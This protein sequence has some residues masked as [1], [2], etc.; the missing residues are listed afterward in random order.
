[1]AADEQQPREKYEKRQ[2]DKP[3]CDGARRISSSFAALSLH[4]SHS[5][6]VVTTP[7]SVPV[8]A[9]SHEL[10]RVHTNDEFK[11]SEEDLSRRLL[12]GE[13][14]EAGVGIPEDDEG[15]GVGVGKGR[16]S[17][18]HGRK[19]SISFA[20]EALTSDG[21]RW[22]LEDPVIPRSE[23]LEIRPPSTS[24]NE[25]DDWQREDQQGSHMH[26]HASG[27][28][29]E[30]GLHIDSI[31]GSPLRKDSG[32]EEEQNPSDGEASLTSSAMTAS[33]PV[34]EPLT[35]MN[36]VLSPTSA[37]S[38]TSTDGKKPSPF[39][40]TRRTDSQRSRSYQRLEKAANGTTSRRRSTRS[41]N[42]SA[43]P[44]SAFLAQWSRSH[45]S[46]PSAEEPDDEGMEIADSGWIIG[47]TI[48]YGG[49]STVKEVSTLNSSSGKRIVRA[50]K[51]MRKRPRNVHDSGQNE[52][53]QA[54]FEHE[55]ALWRFL[56]HRY[57][58]PLIAV[59]DTPFATFCVTKLNV[60]GTLHDL[61]RSRRQ[62]Y[63]VADRGLS[64][65]L[66][67]RYAYQLA[68]AIRY[69]H[70]DARIVHRD[71]KLENC[72]L[73]MTAPDSASHG[74]NI[75]LCDF[76]MADY[77]QT[78]SRDQGDADGEAHNIGP[79]ASSSNLHA[80]SANGNASS[81]ATTPQ[82]LTDLSNRDTS[83]TIMGSLEYAAPEVVTATTTLFSPKADV[84][85]FGVC[86]YA[87]LTAS[88]P[89]S[90]GMREALALMIEKS[91]WDIAPLYSAPAV[92]GGGLAGMAAVELVKGCLTYEAEE[93][94]SVGEVLREKWFINCVELYGDG[95]LR[96]EEVEEWGR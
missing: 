96:E 29:K 4:P 43:S 59:Y 88:L 77:I 68:A 60:G 58:V 93:R 13:D 39:W 71:I 41:A 87:L 25:D 91:Q 17:P 32:I 3:A 63:S 74:G 65:P 62:Q 67:K 9:H 83:L 21:E 61:I 55:V 18:Q 57:I 10:L 6:D 7:V 2:I 86:V 8:H 34:A 14:I 23:P 49:F 51:I 15:V 64:A 44:A 95:N 76:G 40:P 42:S 84:W 19:A 47:R 48:G 72:L 56:K 36:G 79:A 54:E 1:M 37:P 22:K 73:D 94:L 46:Q 85:A 50:V 70:E 33:P 5:S 31:N 80:R 78:D 30:L 52:R 92:R 28:R 69:L 66:A 16:Y 27:K 35:P 89:F 24:N 38:T 75:L 20:G 45:G 11:S 12:N 81:G 90:H 26:S 53:V 82:P